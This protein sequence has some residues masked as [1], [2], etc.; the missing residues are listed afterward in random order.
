MITVSAVAGYPEKKAQSLLSSV[1][2]VGGSEGAVL[3]TITLKSCNRLA[4]K[5]ETFVILKY[6]SLSV[7]QHI[8]ILKQG[9]YA[10]VN[11]TPSPP[12]RG[13]TQGF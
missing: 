11:V 6:Q 5:Y 12:P 7:K 10:L 4:R 9:I 13:H 1:G 2:A 3:L 8:V